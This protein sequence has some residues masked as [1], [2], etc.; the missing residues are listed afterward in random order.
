MIVGSGGHVYTHDIEQVGARSDTKSA[1]H[2]AAA[3]VFLAAIRE[4]KCRDCGARAR[5]LRDAG[6]PQCLRR[7]LQHQASM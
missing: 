5:R 3:F 1:R 4:N 6:A 2:D 7:W